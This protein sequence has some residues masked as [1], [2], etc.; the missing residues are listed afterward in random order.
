MT[1]AAT[2]LL[3]DPSDRSR[4]LSLSGGIWGSCAPLANASLKPAEDAFSRRPCSRRTPMP[5]F[6]GRP[7]SR[8]SLT[9]RDTGIPR[10]VFAPEQADRARYRYS[11]ACFRAQP[12]G[13]VSNTVSEDKSKSGR[14]PQP[15]TS[16][17]S[18]T[19]SPKPML[20]RRL[21]RFRSRPRHVSRW[22]WISEGWRC[23]RSRWP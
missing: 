21:S 4:R 16:A 17:R 23:P 10:R 19:R 22:T 12:Q 15:A 8:P 9:G 6:R 11:Q 14:A 3:A 1:R 13:T 5:S 7:R 20:G 18:T 2:V